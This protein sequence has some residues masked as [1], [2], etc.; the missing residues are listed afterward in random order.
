ME[1]S[2]V[3]LCIPYMVHKV[4]FIFQEINVVGFFILTI[5]GAVDIVIVSCRPGVAADFDNIPCVGSIIAGSSN[6]SD[7]KPDLF[8]HAVERN[9]ISL[10]DCCVVAECCVGGVFECIVLIFKISIIIIYGITDVIVYGFDFLVVA[11]AGQCHTIER[12]IDFGGKLLF[13]FIGG[14]VY[15]LEEGGV[16]ICFF[17]CG[18]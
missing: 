12:L 1:R 15:R 10:A 18:I 14:V 6:D 7:R 16:C 3:V 5:P 13:L 11:L 17:I 9:C 8:T 2:R 4:L